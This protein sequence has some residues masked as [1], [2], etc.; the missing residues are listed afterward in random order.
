LLDGRKN[1]FE[2]SYRKNVYTL[3]IFS[4]PFHKSDVIKFALFIQSHILILAEG[5]MKNNHKTRIFSIVLILMMLLG[6]LGMPSSIVQAAGVMLDGAVS[7]NTAASGTTITINHT[8][9]TGT[10][11]LMLVGVSWNCGTTNRTITGVTFTPDA[12]SPVGLTEVI[13]RLG[14]NASNPRYSAIYSLLNPPIGQ[15][16]TVTITFS[17]SVSSGIMAGAANFSGVNQITPLG[18]PNGANGTNSTSPSVDLTGLNGDEL[19]FDNVFL[20]AGSSSYTL[21]VGPGQTQ[22]WNPAYV[23]NLRAAASIEQATS[24]SVT[25]SWTASTQNYWAITAVPINPAPAGPTHDLTIA[26]AGTGTGTVDPT[27]GVHTYAENTVVPLVATPAIGSTFDGWSGNV[28]CEDGSVTMD[29]DKACTATFSAIEY[30]LSIT[31]DHGTVTKN[32]NQTTYHF[33]DV[34]ELTAEPD[35]GYE[36]T[37]WTGDLT[38][39][40]NPDL[41]TMDGNKSVTANYLDTTGLVI[42]DGAVSSSTADDVNTMT[43]PHTTGTGT[44][45]LMLVG[46]SWNCG[47]VDRTITSITF[48]PDAGSPVGL[49]EV[50]TRL[51][52]NASNPRYSAI[53]SLLNPPS[54]QTGT[55][56][57]NFSGSVSNGIMAGAAN[58]AGVDQTTPLGTPNGADGN[59]ST[60]PSVDLTGLNG[61][62]LVFDNVFLGASSTSYTLAAGP[63]QTQLWNPT[64]IANLRAAASIQRATSSLITMSWTASIQNYW[65]I[66]AVPINPA[67]IQYTLTASSSG[68]GSVTL[69]PSGGT[70]LAN[71]TVTLTPVPDANYHFVSWSG[72]DA[73]DII[74]TGGVYTIVMDADKSVTANFAIDTHTLTVAAGTGGTITAPPSPVTT[75]DYGSVVSITAAPSTGYHFVNWTGDVSTVDDVNAA[76]TTITMN[77]DYS[78]TANFA[79]DT[80]TLTVAAGTGGTITA[81]P[82]P[83]TTHDYGSVVSIIAASATGYHFVDWTGDV[84]TVDDVNAASTT[85]TMEGDYSITANFAID[86]YTLTASNDGNGSVTL[87]PAGG[88]YDYGTTVT[89]TPVANTDYHFVSWTGPDA[90]D[91]ID[92]DGVYTI[93]MD[94]DKSVTANFAID[95]YTLTASSS[96]NGLVTLD[97]AGGTYDY[98]TTITLTVVPDANYHFVSWTGPDAGDIIDTDGVYTIVMDADKSVTAN[99]AIDTYTLTASSSGNGLVTL[100]PAGGTYDYG[101]TITLTVVPDANYHFVS[102]TGPDAADIIDTDGVYT[103]VMDGD[104]SVTANFAIDMFT[105]TVSNDGHGSVTLNPAGGTYDYGTTVT[106]TPVPNANYHFL[107]WT[108]PDAAD[109]IDT[110]GVYTIVMDSDKSVTANF[111]PNIHYTFL[112]IIHH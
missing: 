67:P 76:S 66:T 6:A 83:V 63:G 97:P 23:A 26:T 8:T 109:I 48:T 28:D 15:A 29:T 92:T 110:S 52:Y 75:H 44:D 82:S 25:M 108:G 43:F 50:I 36:F 91:I 18:T 11:R 14:Y 39:T 61:D 64:Y 20:G 107:S 16:G 93:V 31:S 55:V 104:K 38:S 79:I 112:P 53:Y 71:T 98:G 37:G 5:R 19:V 84:S 30:T 35:P 12:G 34:V 94:A 111:A 103:I 24:S 65:A 70:Y 22:L 89:I 1:K 2:T 45:R 46:V 33:N 102:W 13:T 77:G 47:T 78:I 4:Y 9:G 90:A 96:G 86:T 60:A 80:H 68:H 95:T 106:L 57:I 49:T 41:I 21:S 85:I 81:P 74:D 54:G 3:S 87:D 62:E 32:P 105:L 58:F 59:N 88:T 40:D 17:G 69:N 72:M 56:T 73:G 100:D 101:T 10:D 51:G 42:L 27:V 7:V 99:F